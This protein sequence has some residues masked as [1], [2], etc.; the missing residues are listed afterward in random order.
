MIELM[1]PQ[2]TLEESGIQDGDII[3]FQVDISDQGARKFK[4]QGLSSNPRQFYEVLQKRVK[5]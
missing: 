2:L 4:S 5:E 1:T 3:C